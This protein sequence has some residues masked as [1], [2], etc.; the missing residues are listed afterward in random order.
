MSGGLCKS[1]TKK[2]RD[3]ARRGEVVRA[4]ADARLTGVFDGARSA[5]PAEGPARTGADANGAPYVASD[6]EG[7]ARTAV[8]H[9]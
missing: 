8:P 7:P 3:A 9:E 5:R 1:K 2:P 6:Y 4:D